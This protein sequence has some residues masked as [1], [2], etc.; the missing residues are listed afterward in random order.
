MAI[1]TNRAIAT[2]IL[3]HRLAVLKNKENANR[4]RVHKDGHYKIREI[5]SAE[6][7]ITGAEWPV[8]VYEYGDWPCDRDA[9]SH[10]EPGRSAGELDIRKKRKTTQESAHDDLRIREERERERERERKR[11]VATTP[12]PCYPLPSPVPLQSHVPL[13][14]PKAGA[15]YS[16]HIAYQ[17]MTPLSKVGE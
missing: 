2:T 3:E 4:A 10:Q 16:T 1:Q 6:V 9:K 12:T 5:C 13:G 11:T 17:A 8:A 7:W 14:L 15:E